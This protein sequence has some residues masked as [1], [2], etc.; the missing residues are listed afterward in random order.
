MIYIWEIYVNSGLCMKKEFLERATKLIKESLE[1]GLEMEQEKKKEQTSDSYDEEGW[2]EFA[3][4]CEWAHG[5]PY[6]PIEKKHP[7]IKRC[8]QID[9]ETRSGHLWASY[10][11]KMYFK[12]H[13]FPDD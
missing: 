13:R 4:I 8:P 6:T 5:I 3:K 10:I 7:E 2:K 9:C 11:T 12:Y 1:L